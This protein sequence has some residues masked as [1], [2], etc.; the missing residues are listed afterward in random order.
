MAKIESRQKEK[1]ENRV[2]YWCHLYIR[3]RDLIK[4]KDGKIWGK[5]ISC[6]KVWEV[7]LFSDRSIYN[8]SKWVASHYFLED[9]NASVR[10][11]EDNI[12]LGCEHCNKRLSGNLAEY[13]VNLRKKLGDKRFDELV[14]RKN[15]LKKYS[16][17]ELEEL[18]EHYQ[19]KAKEEAKRLGVKI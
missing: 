18:K 8:G 3:L 2:R 16:Y 6:N 7:T 15:Q 11:D 13:E 12:H 4:E 9:R 17:G 10:Y 19:F 14:F 5:C 1:L